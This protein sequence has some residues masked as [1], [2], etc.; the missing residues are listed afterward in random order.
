MF[1][2]TIGV[3]REIG[4]FGENLFGTDKNRELDE[5][6]FLADVR[7]QRIK[8]LDLAEI[9]GADVTFAKWGHPKIDKGVLQ[10]CTAEAAVL[11]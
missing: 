10:S 8:V 4:V 11:G 2:P 1:E 7:V 6:A 5:E 9:L 3:G